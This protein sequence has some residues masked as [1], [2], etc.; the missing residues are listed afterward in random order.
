MLSQYRHFGFGSAK[1]VVSRYTRITTNSSPPNLERVSPSRNACC[2]RTE[3]AISNG[4]PIACIGGH[5][6]P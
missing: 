3:R 4:S 1:Y 2:I 6:P 5:L